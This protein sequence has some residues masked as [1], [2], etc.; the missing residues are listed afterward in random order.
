MM[1]AREFLELKK[2]RNFKRIRN[3]DFIRFE[4]ERYE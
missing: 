2:V 3:I 4:F 1:T